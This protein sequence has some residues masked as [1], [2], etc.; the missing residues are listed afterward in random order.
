MEE[1]LGR[2]E[3]KNKKIKWS[4]TMFA[5]LQTGLCK[6]MLVWCV[7]SFGMG[8]INHEAILNFVKIVS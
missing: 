3:K 5:T 4:E 7:A 2:K 1:E 6:L 8:D